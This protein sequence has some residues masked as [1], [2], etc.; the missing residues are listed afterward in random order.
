M[1]RAVAEH[2]YGV[3]RR[4]REEFENGRDYYALEGSLVRLPLP[5]APPPSVEYLEWHGDTVFRVSCDLRTTS[6]KFGQ[7]NEVR[8]TKAG[9]LPKSLGVFLCH[10]PNGR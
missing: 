8:P 2:R 4:I 5:P 7:R 1:E 9:R 3:S 6:A 10:R